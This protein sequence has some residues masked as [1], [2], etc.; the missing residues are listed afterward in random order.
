MEILGFQLDPSLSIFKNRFHWWTLGHNVSISASSCL[1]FWF[2]LNKAADTTPLLGFC[3]PLS[4]QL[5]WHRGLTPGVSSTFWTLLRV[6]AEMTSG[7]VGL[8]TFPNAGDLS[9]CHLF[10]TFAQ[11]PLNFRLTHC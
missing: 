8:Q 7:G 9:C 2:F 5:S 3:L 11:E 6:S 10:V 4:L 1:R